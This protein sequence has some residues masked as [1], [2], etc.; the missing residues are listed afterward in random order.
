MFTPFTLSF[1]T[2]NY[3][4]QQ[5]A[6]PRV[7]KQPVTVFKLMQGVCRRYGMSTSSCRAKALVEY[8]GESFSNEKCLLYV[9][10]L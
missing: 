2:T 8:F 7:N 4:V 9:I 6:L 10:F 1:Y 5:H 3:G